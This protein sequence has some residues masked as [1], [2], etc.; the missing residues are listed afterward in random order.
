MS[1]KENIEAQCDNGSE[2]LTTWSRGII[3]PSA[4]CH[5]LHKQIL[6]PKIL[7]GKHGPKFKDEWVNAKT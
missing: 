7:F 3:S 5:F 6:T 1:I 4:F 2:V